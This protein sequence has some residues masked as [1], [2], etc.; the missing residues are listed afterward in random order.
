MEKLLE[1]CGTFKD[2][3]KNQT[4]RKFPAG[5]VKLVYMKMEMRSIIVTLL[6]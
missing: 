4:T 6:D 2:K 1:N 3:R 5:S